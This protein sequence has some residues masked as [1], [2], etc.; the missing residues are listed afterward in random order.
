[1][2]GRVRPGQ[3]LSP[4]EHDV[5]RCLTRGLTYKQAAHE[6]GVVPSTIRTM[7]HNA[8]VKLGAVDKNTA[9]IA[10]LNSEQRVEETVE[11][12]AHDHEVGRLLTVGAWRRIVRMV[13]AEHLGTLTT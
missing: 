13:L 3:P 12:L 2:N 9:M 7:T 4:R 11:A 5:L 6:L 8:Y 1:M 10:Y